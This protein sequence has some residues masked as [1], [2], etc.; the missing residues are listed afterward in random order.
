MIGTTHDGNDI[1]ID[2]GKL[3]GTHLAIVGNTGS[4]KTYTVR[5]VLEQTWGA[6]L[7]IVIDPEGEF[8]TLRQ[9]HPYVIVGGPR[10]KMKVT[11][12]N[13][14]NLAHDIL[15]G[16]MSVVLQFEDAQ[17]LEIQ[18]RIIA[19]LIDALMAAP[20]ALWQPV[21]IVLDEAHRYAPQDGGAASRA[22]I[23]TLMS[24]GRKRGFTGILATQRLAKISKSAVSE[25][26]TWL[27]GRVGQVLDR[28]A[29]AN[30]LGF[31]LKSDEALGLRTLN[32]GQFWGFGVAISK[33]PVLIQVAATDTQHLQLGE[34]WEDDLQSGAAPIAVPGA[35]KVG[36]AAVPLI[37]V[38]ICLALVRFLF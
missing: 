8:H 5:K 18:R 9:A 19:G 23:H 13:V 4:G 30:N 28:N 2:A 14:A 7:H 36:V 16:Q 33:L 3:I 38:V 12:K 37:A 17:H 11:P 34:S 20:R 29:A 31:P 35:P 27:I 15:K 10:S 1:A 26:N 32:P 21:F 22:S 24:Q 25:C 6:A